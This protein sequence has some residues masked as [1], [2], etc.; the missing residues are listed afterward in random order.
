MG[1]VLIL[2]LVGGVALWWF[3]IRPPTLAGFP[4][5]AKLQ[6]LDN[7]I[8]NKTP[9]SP[10]DRPLSQEELDQF[11]S[12]QRAIQKPLKDIVTIVEKQSKQPL[13]QQPK[14]SDHR[15]T[16]ADPTQTWLLKNALN[17]L[18]LAKTAQVDALNR[19]D[20]SEA[21]YTWIRGEVT[22]AYFGL[23]SPELDMDSL[24][25]P[26]TNLKSLLNGLGIATS[27]SSETFNANK[28]LLAP[29]FIHGELDMVIPSFI[30]DGGPTETRS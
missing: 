25:K 10:V 5:L 4:E 7:K 26:E 24:F 12:V 18:L 2:S 9:F 6:E 21:K 17:P 29:H 30:L 16:G 14:E 23:M 8:Q 11:L 13:E 28:T 15:T 19:L 3:V 22:R 1:V 27:V 20:L